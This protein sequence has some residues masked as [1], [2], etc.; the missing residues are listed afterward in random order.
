MTFGFIFKFLK[1]IALEKSKYF[2]VKIF[3]NK[4]EVLHNYFKNKLY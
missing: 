1:I 3:L 2:Q 4:V